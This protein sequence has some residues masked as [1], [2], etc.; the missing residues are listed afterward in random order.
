VPGRI[1]S[2]SSCAR[3]DSRGGGPHMRPSLAQTRVN[4]PH[5]LAKDGEMGHPGMQNPGD[6]TITIYAQ[7]ESRMPANLVV[8]LDIADD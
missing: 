5:S 4:Y 1:G 6:E 2:D 8:N 7:A 3:L